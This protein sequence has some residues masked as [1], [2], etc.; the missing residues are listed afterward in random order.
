[1]RQCCQRVQRV[2]H[3]FFR[4]EQ[5]VMK[6]PCHGVHNHTLGRQFRCNTGNEADSLQ[7]GMD[8][9]G[10]HPAG[11]FEIQTCHFRRLTR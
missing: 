9:Q 3:A 7:S 2:V 11:K 10:D 6:E 5:M 1:M 4:D 8:V